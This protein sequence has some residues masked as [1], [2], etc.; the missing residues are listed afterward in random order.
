[1][2]NPLLLLLLFLSL[3]R[4]FR[5][6]AHDAPQEAE[7][8]Q[9]K[10][11]GEDQCK[12]PFG[13]AHTGGAGLCM[14]RHK[15]VHLYDAA[16]SHKAANKRTD[17]ISDGGAELLQPSGEV[18]GKQVDLGVSRIHS[19][20]CARQKYD[21]NMQILNDLSGCGN[22]LVKDLFTQHIEERD[23]H[24]SDEADARNVRHIFQ[25]SY[26][27]AIHLVVQ[28]TRLTGQW[29]SSFSL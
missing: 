4:L 27:Y 25:N 14:C 13:K 18:A 21:G 11:N 9:E 15:L 26:N 22:T 17:Q 28:C 19:Y 7:S 2:H 23:K 29:Y 20:I 12:G 16:A 8:Q 1:M 10:A 3:R 6:L 24:D 5:I